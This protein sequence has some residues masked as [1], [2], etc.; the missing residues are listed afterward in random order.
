[1]SSQIRSPCRVNTSIVLAFVEC[2][3]FAAIINGWPSIVFILKDSNLFS[4]LC[5]SNDTE[6]GNSSYHSRNSDEQFSDR[7]TTC[8]EADSMFSL[9]FSVASAVF[10]ISSF[11]VG[12]MFDRYGFWVTRISAT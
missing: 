1:M 7:P 2:V 8:S 3:C 11:P 12:L 5:H 9:C 4:N 6:D 10:Q